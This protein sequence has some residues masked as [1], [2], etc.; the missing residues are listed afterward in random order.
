MVRKAYEQI[1]NGW[2]M[3]IE[4]LENDQL[5]NEQLKQELTVAP[6]QYKM[7]GFCN[8]LIRLLC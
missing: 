1:V 2:E 6:T 4:G 7:T 8:N 3:M 5:D